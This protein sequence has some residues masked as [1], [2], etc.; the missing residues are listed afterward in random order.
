M[1]TKI[2]S[3]IALLWEASKFALVGAAGTVT[4]LIVFFISG[5]LLGINANIASVLAF[6]F[7]VTQNYFGNKL[8]TFQS[9]TSS[10]FTISEYLKFV[11][12]S[13]AG[14]AVNLVILNIILGIWK[15]IPLKVI[16]Q[17][18]GIGGG[19]VLNFIFSRLF[20]FKRKA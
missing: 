5:D 12:V 20:V 2:K 3:K 9:N 6:S 7:A 10:K 19:L 13:L 1:E 14:L 4:N 15:N 18:A 17:L 16:A 11:S 8:W